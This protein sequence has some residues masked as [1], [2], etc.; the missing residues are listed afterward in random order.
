MVSTV[1]ILIFMV[2]LGEIWYGD[3]NTSFP[4]FLDTNTVRLLG[5]NIGFD[6]ITETII[7][8]AATAI[9]YYFFRFVRL[10]VAMR[11]VVD[12]PELV[13]MTDTNPVVVR[14]WAWIIARQ[15]TLPMRSGSL[16]IPSC[17]SC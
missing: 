3:A 1:G 11:G 2:G 5:V 17:R 6:Q 14:R 12:N 9:L 13:S 4:S 10:G 16:A 8:V 15:T 7:A